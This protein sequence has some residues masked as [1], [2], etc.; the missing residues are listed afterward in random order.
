MKLK[1]FSFKINDFKKYEFFK[2]L[3]FF[4]PVVIIFSSL[5]I[6][7]YVSFFIF[8]FPYII[9]KRKEI[10]KAIKYSNLQQSLV[11][12]YFF[13]LILSSLYGSY[14]IED[15]R[16]AIFFL[17]LIITFI[18]VYYK[19]IFDL[20]NY[21]F[22]R[23]NYLEIIY[24]ASACYFT[25]YF[26]MNIFSLFYFGN[27][28]QIQDNI[29]MG[30]SGA[31]SISSLLFFSLYKLWGKIN[32][33]LFSNY[34]IV[35]LIYIFHV[36]LNESR[37]GIVY[38]ITF[39]IFISIR[40][41]HLKSF[42]SLIIFLSISLSSYTIYSSIIGSFYNQFTE[43]KVV[44]SNERNIIYDTKNLFQSPDN[45]SNELIKGYRKFKEYP[46]LNKLIGT[47]W[48]SSRITI[49][50][51]ANEIKKGRINHNSY[52]VYHMQGIVAL[53]LDTGILG[54]LFLFTLL[55]LNI[56]N[57][58]RLKDNLTNKLFNLSMI[59][60]VLLCLFIGYSLVNIAYVLFML[61]DGI[62]YIKNNKLDSRD[63]F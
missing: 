31:F 49:N 48:Y 10:L 61:P 56:V 54:S 28:Y 4:L 53:I 15:I 5:K 12:I 42:L 17:P 36:F 9:F 29:W 26:I 35:F 58:L 34:F 2:Y 44:R 41:I 45:R 25:L 57:H 38:I 18:S 62:T 21:K 30:S 20:N 13:Y 51:N 22:Y 60:I 55:V 33:N 59:S 37:L 40:K 32:Y 23:E 6:F 63:S 1:S 14:F 46:L 43:T 24:F 50:A 27:A 47:G 7:G 8:Y 3:D 11:L 39:T 16:I 52:P 19:N